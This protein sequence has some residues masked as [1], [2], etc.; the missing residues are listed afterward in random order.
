MLLALV[1]TSAASS[2]LVTA[3]R[4]AVS[5]VADTETQPAAPYVLD[6]SHALRVPDGAVA[7][8]LFEGR[9]I[10][11]TGPALVK[12]A[13][14]S[15]AGQATGQDP[16]VLADLMERGVSTK[17]AGATRAGGTTLTRPLAGAKVAQVPTLA[18]DCAGC[19]EQAVTLTS[20][21]DDQVVWTGTGTDGLAYDGP[22]LEPGPYA[23]KVGA[24]EFS[25]RVTSGDEQ[26]QV[27]AIVAGS[28]ITDPVLAAQVEAGLYA[29]SG[30]Y[31]EALW[32]LDAAQ[33]TSP[34]PELSAL[35][36]ELEQRAGL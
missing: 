15:G 26:A 34:S 29:Q 32:A 28:G 31:S 5:L 4:G 8:V 35:Q 6:A 36:R 23:V 21:L 27:Q 16:S 12:T 20:F 7:V 33:A 13:E 10:Q 22:A 18:W 19:G 24:H 25:F 3:A 2:A 17:S 9:A 11:V 14:L 1:A 30:F